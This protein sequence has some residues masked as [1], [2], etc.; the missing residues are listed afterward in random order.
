MTGNG[1][2]RPLE[3]GTHVAN[4]SLLLLDEAFDAQ[5]ARFL[6][7]LRDVDQLVPLARFTERW[8]RDP[9]PWAREQILAYLQQP[10]SG[11]GQ[12]AVV[13]RLLRHAETTG[14]DELMA[15]FLPAFDRLVRHD[16]RQRWRYDA[17]LQQ[18]VAIET[19]T[20]PKNRTPLGTRHDPRLPV[21]SSPADRLFTYHTRYYLRRRAW[22][23]FRRL[24]HQR[25]QDYVPAVSRALALYLDDDLARGEHLLESWSLMQ[26]CFATHEAVQHNATRFR[27]TPGHT[28]AELQP[29]PRFAPLWDTQ[30]GFD[31][32]WQLLVAARS[33]LVRVWARQLIER[34][35]SVS[36]AE[37][38]VEHVLP[39]LAHGDEEVQQ[40]GANVFR[41]LRGL[42]ELPV[43]TWLRCLETR[44]L[45]A[46][47]V[48]CAAMQSHVPADKLSLAE[49]VQLACAAPVPLSQL[50]MSYLVRRTHSTDEERQVLAGLSDTRCATTARELTRWALARL[51]SSTAYDRDPITRFFDARL[52]GVRAA[53]WEWLTQP[54]SAGWD[55]AGLWLRLLETPYD[56]LRLPLID[57]LQDRS[58][59]PPVGTRD[60]GPLWSTILLGVQRGGRQKRKAVEQ[61]RDA[62]GQHPE[63]ADALLP[64]LAVAVRSVRAPESRAGLSAIATLITQHPEWRE[65][66]S[67]LLPEVHFP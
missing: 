45:G 11:V 40:F 24:A 55:D 44:D 4:G 60:L 52:P 21:S 6:E 38:P 36:L 56:D 64:L 30:T 58:H 65:R 67:Q 51:D 20:L 50:G 17:A 37:L 5:D 48:L 23:Y 57:A 49:C 27:L 13:K 42:A 59:A 14:D 15:C 33:R 16:R 28:L 54:N 53:A 46:L 18:A 7:R 1:L 8:V 10:L 62:L 61:L 34:L 32:L 66:L 2:E 35:H 19:L 29:A 43:A 9:R 25:P 39:L 31:A 12:Q 41:G 22:R 63:Q 47:E 26:A 3:D